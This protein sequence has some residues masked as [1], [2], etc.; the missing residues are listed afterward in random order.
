MPKDTLEQSKIMIAY[1]DSVGLSKNYLSSKMPE[2]RY[3]S[4]FFYKSTYITRRHFIEQGKYW[5]ENKRVP[6]AVHRRSFD[7]NKTYLGNI[8]MVHCKDDATKWRVLISR[9]FRTYEFLK[10]EGFYVR[11][12]LLLNECSYNWYESEK[13]KERGKVLVEYYMELRN[14]KNAEH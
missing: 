12:A 7:G 4:M 9:R 13:D 2:I 1:F 14:K 10:G 11:N 5:V 6:S 8:L 3:Y